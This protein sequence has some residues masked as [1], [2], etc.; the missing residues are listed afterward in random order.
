[1]IQNMLIGQMLDQIQQV[2]SSVIELKSGQV[3]SGKVLKLFPDNMATVQL[4]GLTV[5]ARLETPLELGQRTWLQ[6]QPGGQPVTLKVINQPGQPNVAADPGL[7]GLARGLGASVNEENMKLLKTLVDQNVPLKADS[8]RAFQQVMSEAG[9][10]QE[11]LDAALLAFK[12]GLPVTKET[13]LSLRAFVANTSI[14]SSLT[15]LADS[16]EQAVQQPQSLLS[17]SLKQ[18]VEQALPALRSTRAVLEQTAE[19]LAGNRGEAADTDEHTAWQST[20][21]QT[22]ASAAKT[23][24]MELFDRLGLR[25]ERELASSQLAMPSASI[26]TENES[27]QAVSQNVKAALLHLLQHEDA[28]LLPQ[29]VR[30]QVQLAIHQLTGQQLMTA[31]A[32]DSAFVQV[33]LQLPMPG[34]PDGENALIQ[35]ESRRKRNGELDPD[36]CRLF[37]YLSMQNMGETMLDVSVVNRILSVHLYND[38]EQIP[39]M[40]SA[41]RGP[42]EARLAEQGYRLSSIRVS[43][44]P[45]EGVASTASSEPT[46][47]QGKSKPFATPP[48][49]LANY[50][51]VDF[52]I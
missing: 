3:F 18:A 6:V 40:V 48:S 17:P 41:L 15:G 30:E 47:S 27:Q 9:N 21:P 45:D 39:E 33:A 44:I 19:I 29:G 52:R 34:N 14:G 49:S 26:N 51:G 36:N 22:D 2:R 50:K 32:P 35:V 12:K 5:T 7:E 13:V 46:A 16:L 10:N 25:H 20:R 37:F 38:G 4:G 23:I 43:P 8:L 31:N 24:V 1:M 11:T 42:L 28:Q